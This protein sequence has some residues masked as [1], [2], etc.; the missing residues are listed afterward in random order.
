MRDGQ[1][2]TRLTARPRRWLTAALA[3]AAV[4]VVLAGTWGG[5]AVAQPGV[6]TDLQ[7]KAY[8]G[9]ITQDDQFVYVGSPGGQIRLDKRNVAKLDFAA[10]I[11]NQY[12]LRHDKLAGDDVKGRMDLADW[13]NGNA[14]PD[15]SVAVLEEARQ[16]EPTNRDV[17]L[18]LDAIQRQMDL[19]RRRGK[20]FAAVRGAVRPVPAGGKSTTGPTTA[21]ATTAPSVV[22]RLLRADEINAIRQIEMRT[23]DRAVKVR[24]DHNVVRRYILGSGYDAKRFNKL[25]GEEQALEILRNGSPD[26]AN[27]VRILTDPTPLKLF[28]TKVMPIIALGCA[29]TACHGG[30]HAGDFGLYTGDTTEATYTNFYILQTYATQIDGVKYLAMD[31]ETPERSLVLQFGLPPLRGKPPHP[32][33]KDWRPRFHGTDDPAYVTVN[34]YLTDAL[35]VIQPDYGFNVAS[36]LPPSTQPAATQPAATAPAAPPLPTSRP[37][38]HGKPLPRLRS[39]AV[40]APSE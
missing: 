18:K 16:I 10:D 27:D 1:Q 26:M 13:A 39:G 38:V 12:K 31:R 15:L 17:A 11:D 14:R 35:R 34:D 21:M 40:T 33:A 8:G 25:S 9:D 22:R 24:F 7:G 3:A 36:K 19:D 6:V 4:A 30:T 32:V 20:A 23:D 37:V 28:K 2:E 5:P 29:S